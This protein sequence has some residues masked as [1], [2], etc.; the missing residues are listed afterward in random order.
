MPCGIAWTPLSRSSP[1]EAQQGR[2]SECGSA[3]LVRCVLASSSMATVHG[4]ESEWLRRL[5]AKRAVALG[6]YGGVLLA[7][8]IVLATYDTRLA[9]ALLVA[10]IALAHGPRGVARRYRYAYQGAAGERETAKR[11]A[12]L[13]ASFTVLNDLAFSGFNV[14]H[15]VV[16][17]TGVWAIET[18]SRTGVVEERGDDV[19]VNR[20]PMYRDPRRQAR[21]EAAAIAELLERET[22]TRYWIDALVCF[23]NAT[24]IAT[25]N[26]AKAGVV[27]RGRL[28]TRLRLAPAVL[29]RA[30]RARIVEVLTA[31]RERTTNDAA[32]GVQRNSMLGAGRH[33]GRGCT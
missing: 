33:Q 32:V 6:T 3:W 20:R 25:G 9:V 22:A 16:G 1:R 4:E 13:P 11:L 14:D 28:L 26:H 7:T 8:T 30:E 31:A 17:P 12:L 5:V 24:V 21:G 19:W 2:P 15:V 29:R 10:G 23:P 18:K 27:G